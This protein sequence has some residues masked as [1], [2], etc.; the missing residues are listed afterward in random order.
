[1]QTKNPTIFQIIVVMVFIEL[2]ALKDLASQE[3]ETQA[4][5]HPIFNVICPVFQGHV[6]SKLFDILVYPWLL[7]DCV[8][9]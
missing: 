2:G 4:L 9:L 6:L 1:M 8:H 7:W 5:I 3:I